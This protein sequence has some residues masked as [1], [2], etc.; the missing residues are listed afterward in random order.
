MVS[1]LR[2]AKPA[3][4]MPRR[5]YL[6]LAATHSKQPIGLRLVRESGETWV[7]LPLLPPRACACSDAAQPNTR[8]SRTATSLFEMR[9]L[10]RADGARLHH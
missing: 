1:A 7:V 2:L 8:V 5:W 9:Q 3:S 10:S 6:S 4:Q